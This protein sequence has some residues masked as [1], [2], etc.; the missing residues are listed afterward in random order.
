MFMDFAKRIF[1][2]LRRLCA[3]DDSETI[4]RAILNSKRQLLEIFDC[5]HDPILIVSRDFKILRLNKAML[6][7]LNGKFKSYNDVI[8]LD[9]FSVL[10]C[11][12]SICDQCLVEDVFTGRSKREGLQSQV[13]EFEIGGARKTFDISVFPLAGKD[14][15]VYAAVKYL[16]D[17]TQL[18]R[19]QTELYEAERSHVLGSLA[20]GLAH[21]IRNPLAVISSTAQFMKSEMADGDDA[22]NVELIIRNSDQA[23]SVISDLLKFAKPKDATYEVVA[24]EQV[25]EE[26][27]RLVKERLSKNK[28]RLIKKIGKDVPHFDVNRH[29]FLQAYVNI[30]LSAADTMQGGGKIHVEIVAME[31][32]KR[33]KVIIRDTGHGFSP[34]V[35]AR[36]FKPFFRTRGGP[37]GL[38]LPIAGDIIKSLGGTVSFESKEDEGSTV[39]ISLPMS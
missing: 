31:E 23:N 26:G 15:R 6:T 18:T 13:S 1:L 29:N 36:A 4:S 3:P 12:D 9:C 30:L 24:I 28:I 11:R 32:D 25:L 14:G 16:R 10:H 22:E 5:I 37:P 35:A 38:K 21:E 8:G 39:V 20:V 34:E 2:R 17:V 33:L 27:A 7:L 19:L